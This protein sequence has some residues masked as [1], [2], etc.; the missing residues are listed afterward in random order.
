MALDE[1]SDEDCQAIPFIKFLP[2]EGKFELDAEAKQF[3][4]GLVDTKLGIVAVCG[5]YRTGKSYLMNKLFVEQYFQRKR[6]QRESKK[7]GFTVSPTIN[8]CTKGLW[9]WKKVIKAENS[10]NGQ[11]ISMIVVDTEGLGA[12][13]EDENHDAKIF[14]L[15]LLLSS[16]LIYNSVGTIDENALNSLS[17]V[18]NLSKKI[19]LK[20]GQDSQ[21]DV[22]TLS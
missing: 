11:E 7:G 10:A 8:A 18:I 1:D 16:L 22:D 20:K 21:D 12:Y 13:D 14:L 4:M 9:L 2:E 6:K 5:K 17:L 3:L 15:A 19:Q